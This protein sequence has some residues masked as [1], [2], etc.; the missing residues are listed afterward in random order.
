MA[1]LWTV[2]ELGR[3]DST[4]TLSSIPAVKPEYEIFKTVNEI[5]ASHRA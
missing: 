2:V 5:W 3:R 4:L 1:S